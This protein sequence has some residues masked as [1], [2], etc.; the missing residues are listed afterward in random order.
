MRS[1]LLR[2]HLAAN[3]DK[4]KSGGGGS[5]GPSPSFGA[6]ALQMRTAPAQSLL[7]ERLREL[8]L[9]R[10]RGRID[11]FPAAGQQCEEEQGLTHH[12]LPRLPQVR[13]R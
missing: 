1:I 4:T 3:D 12:H 9:R 2:H 8:R 7:P 6:T 10:R 13:S 11:R 5:G